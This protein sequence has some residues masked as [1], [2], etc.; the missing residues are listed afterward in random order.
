MATST[1]RA[2]KP[3]RLCHLADVHLGYRRFHRL[4][5]NGFNQREVDVCLAFREAIDRVIAIAPDLVVIA[6]DLFHSVRPS[7]A[8]LTFGFREL[9]RLRRALPAPIVVCAGNHETPRR[10]DTGS[11]LRLL[12]EIDG[13]FVAEEGERFALPQLD[14]M[15][16]CLPHRAALGLAEQP[17][18]V[19]GLLRA[20]ERYRYNVLV[21][22]A[23]V[24]AGWVSDFGGAELS[25]DALRPWEWDYVALGH[26]HSAREL[27]RHVRY[28]GAIE[29]TSNNFW[30]EAEENKGF[31]EVQL[32]EARIVHHA[33]TS[34][35]EV[36]ALAPIDAEDRTP[37]QLDELIRDALEGIPGG[38]AG[39]IVR[40]ELRGI[41]RAVFRM[42]DHKALRRY[43]ASALNLT[44]E[45]RTSISRPA[46]R[47][48]KEGARETL[49]GELEA[50]C[51]QRSGAADQG[52]VELLRGYLR[53]VETP[54]EDSRATS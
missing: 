1:R 30:A 8:I 29:H 52:L 34:P 6:G 24:N 7:N 20:D 47:V 45:S 51:R 53:Q 35:R 11:P 2:G 5:R 21:A 10:V 13:V 23:Q 49:E 3:L 43:R 42:L 39:K 50:F 15:V 4:A 25:L 22:H 40:L 17:T 12:R 31:L 37:E 18:Q 19:E 48:A 27:A 32:P 36:V 54:D 9:R 44:V 38:L 46:P 28:S 14:A 16:V 26:V 33:L 41:S